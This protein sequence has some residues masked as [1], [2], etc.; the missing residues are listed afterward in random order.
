MKSSVKG[1]E[2]A[3]A[4]GVAYLEIG[5]NLALAVCLAA[6]ASIGCMWYDFGSPVNAHSR[7]EIIVS[8]V[9]VRTLRPAD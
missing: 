2:E 9:Q 6:A 7:E 8:I 5:I 1:L 4:Q 3:S